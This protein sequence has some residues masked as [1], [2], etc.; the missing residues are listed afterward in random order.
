MNWGI[1]NDLFHQCTL[2]YKPF[3][4]VALQWDSNPRMCNLQNIINYNMNTY[5]V[6]SIRERWEGMQRYSTQTL[7]VIQSLSLSA[8]SRFQ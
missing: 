3:L 7:F 6:P 4:L 8:C 1:A 5:Y 2:L